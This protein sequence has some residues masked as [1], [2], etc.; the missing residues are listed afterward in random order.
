M[1]DAVT[2]TRVA[3]TAHAPPG[4]IDGAIGGL[5][6]QGDTHPH[7]R[8]LAG[9]L[10]RA[11]QNLERK[12]DEALRELASRREEDTLNAL[13][14][15]AADLAWIDAPALTL[16]TAVL[17]LEKYDA[18]KRALQRKRNPSAREDLR[19]QLV[20]IIATD[21]VDAVLDVLERGGYM[22]AP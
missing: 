15:R 14:R 22:E 17:A 13:A 7:A 5:A 3:S 4:D 16:D 10:A 19:E 18:A 12:H 9:P 20:D 2:V 1:N 8:V 21:A 6:M 11:Y